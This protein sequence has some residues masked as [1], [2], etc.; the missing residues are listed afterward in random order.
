MKFSKELI[1]NTTITWSILSSTTHKQST[2]KTIDD[3]KD[4]SDQIKDEMLFF[5]TYINFNKYS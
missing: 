4:R 1:T 2:D 3:W 5:P